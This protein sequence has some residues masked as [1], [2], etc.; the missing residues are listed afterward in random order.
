MPQ[1][2]G[3]PSTTVPAILGS[4]ASV[5]VA[6]AVGLGDCVGVAGVGVVVVGVTGEEAGSVTEGVGVLRDEGSS[7]L[8]ATSA[9]SGTPA[10]PRSSTLLVAR[11]PT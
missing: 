1:G 6:V 11:T 9:A 5:A 2:T 3:I 7:S 8:H 4:G 10:P